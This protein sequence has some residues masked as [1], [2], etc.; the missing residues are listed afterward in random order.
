MLPIASPRIKWVVLETRDRLAILQ[1][2][3]LGA[4]SITL[5]QVVYHMI[6]ETHALYKD[7]GNILHSMETL[8]VQ[9]T[10]V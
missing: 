6:M 2:I 5:P 3:S 9:W 1:A 10:Q 4:M 8:W 7:Q